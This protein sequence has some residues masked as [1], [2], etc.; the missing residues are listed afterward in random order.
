M[1]NLGMIFLSK[2]CRPGDDL[3]WQVELDME[4]QRKALY[5]CPSSL[6]NDSKSLC[7]GPSVT[8]LVMSEHCPIKLILG[9][10]HP[11][12]LLSKVIR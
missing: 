2:Q 5:V 1:G 10:R 12:R 9:H 3:G 7:S 4:Q 8:I 6:S 11:L